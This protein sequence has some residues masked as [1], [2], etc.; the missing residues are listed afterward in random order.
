MDHHHP[1]VNG[2]WKPMKFQKHVIE[3]KAFRGSD[4]GNEKRPHEVAFPVLLRFWT[5]PLEPP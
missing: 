4:Q 1:Q 5:P 2:T 3:L